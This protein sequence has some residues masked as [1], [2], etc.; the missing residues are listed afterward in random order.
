MQADETNSPK[1][2][3]VDLARFKS[4]RL[5]IKQVNKILKVKHIAPRNT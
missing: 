5:L 4:S 2:K 3:V 1:E